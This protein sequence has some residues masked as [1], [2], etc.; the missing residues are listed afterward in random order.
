MSIRRLI[1]FGFIQFALILTAA[2]LLG[3]GSGN[4]QAQPMSSKATA[5]N[6]AQKG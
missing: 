4:G 1:N 3:C 2:V 6:Q 5:H